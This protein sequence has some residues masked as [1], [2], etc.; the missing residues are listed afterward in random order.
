MVMRDFEI[1]WINP[2]SRLD[3]TESFVITTCGVITG[4]G[5]IYLI[6][7]EI[8]LRYFP[9]LF[10]N[11]NHKTSFHNHKFIN[12]NNFSSTHHVTLHKCDDDLSLSLQE[13]R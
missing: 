1:L 13:G 11:P 7:L 10:T 12:H 9:N 5:L 4:L 3:L 2:C 6:I 8:Y